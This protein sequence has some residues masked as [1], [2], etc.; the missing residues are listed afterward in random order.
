MR[1]EEKKTS[2]YV[3]VRT[4][5]YLLEYAFEDLVAESRWIFLKLFTSATCTYCEHFVFIF[6][7]GRH[8]KEGKI[9]LYFLALLS[10]FAHI[11]LLLPT[12][13]C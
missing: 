2:A 8:V 10:F 6:V 5:Y 12:P 1:I 4:E 3:K 9:M 7:S 13:L 11:R